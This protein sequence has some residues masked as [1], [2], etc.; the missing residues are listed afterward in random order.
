MKL[1]WFFLIVPCT[2]F[3]NVEYNA[4]SDNYIINKSDGSTFYIYPNISRYNLERYTDSISHSPSNK[5]AIVQKNQS[6]YLFDEYGK[7][8][9]REKWYCDIINT[10]TG[11]VI[12]TYDGEVCGAEW[13]ENS[14]LKRS[15]GVYNIPKNTEQLPPKEL[16]INLNYRDLDFSIQS[17]MACYPINSNNLFYYKDISKKLTSNYNRESDGSFIK[18][19][20]IT[21]ANL[22]LDTL[23]R[24]MLKQYKL[25]DTAAMQVLLKQFENIGIEDI[26]TVSSKNVRK[27]NDIAFFMEESRHDKAAIKILN[28][29]IKKFPTRTVAYINLGDAYWALEQRKEATDVYI[30]YVNLMKKNKKEKK[31]PERILSR[32]DK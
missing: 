1:F 17:Y 9:K 4:L 14:N 19:A 18:N 30:K 5:L 6:G 23:H 20:L 8:I 2:A 3:S 27:F 13:N 10:S 25:K 16:S 28:K 26:L 24:A 11:C 31:I 29:V 21:E 7:K 12:G 15:N 32:I 22:T